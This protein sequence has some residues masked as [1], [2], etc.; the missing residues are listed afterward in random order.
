[1]QIIVLIFL[2]LFFVSSCA[3]NLQSLAKQEQK[4]RAKQNINSYLALEYL[5]YSRE[6]AHQSNQKYSN[7]FAIKGIKAAQNKEVFPEVPENWQSSWDGNNSQINQANIARR[8]LIGLFFD[9]KTRQILPMQLAHLQLL[10]DC[11]LLQTRDSQKTNSNTKQCSKLFFQLENEINIYLEAI[12]PKKELKIIAIP[13]P[14]FTRF[15]IYFD[16]NLNN[17]NSDTDKKFTELFTYLETLNGDYKILLV[18]NADRVGKKLYNDA[19]ARKRSLVVKNRLIKNGVPEDLI[20]IK[21]LGENNPKIITTPDEQN[22]NN[23]RVG[24]YILKGQDKI[25]IIPLPL[26]DNYIYKQD[27]LEYRIKRG[28]DKKS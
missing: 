20:Q 26:I 27:I 10:Y 15:D 14:Q 8:R 9:L 6:L 7:Y 1:M 16:F 24:I 13:E 17:F 28:I 5:Q 4:L 11:W 18:G 22:K 12:K 21:S 19:L 25:S 23:R 2:T 3:N